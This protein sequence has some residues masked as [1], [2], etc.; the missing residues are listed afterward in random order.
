[1]KKRDRQAGRQASFGRHARQC[2]SG[3]REEVNAAA[4][5]KLRYR[6]SRQRCSIGINDT[7]CLNCP[8]YYRNY[9][10]LEI[11][12]NFL[13]ESFTPFLTQ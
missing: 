3:G 8:F 11:D 4:D 12:Y 6:T 9:D 1:M 5:I 13:F 10:V 7:A 2:F